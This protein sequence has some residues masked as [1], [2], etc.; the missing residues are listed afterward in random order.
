M[1]L[2]WCIAIV[3]SGAPGAGGGASV[4]AGTVSAGSGAS[5]GAAAPVTVTS[6]AATGAGGGAADPTANLQI[7]QP[8]GV[9]EPGCLQ[10]LAF[11]QQFPVHQG[12]KLVCVQVQFPGTQVTPP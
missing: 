8:G 11:V 2:M 12:Q 4:S 9:D 7:I 5:A 10:E 1:W 6:G 3:L